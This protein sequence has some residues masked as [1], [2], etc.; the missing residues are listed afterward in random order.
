MA[1][2]GIIFSLDQDAIQVLR[3]LGVHVEFEDVPLVCKLVKISECHFLERTPGVL[4]LL[5]LWK[6]VIVVLVKE[7]LDFSVLFHGGNVGHLVLVCDSE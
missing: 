4:L 6:Y 1:I 7:L 5:K 3:K 2:K